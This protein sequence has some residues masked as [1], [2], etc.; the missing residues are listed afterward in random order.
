M[1]K[2]LLFLLLALVIWYVVTAPQ[3]AAATATN[4]GSV[5]REWAQAFTAFLSSL[6]A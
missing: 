4:I 3:E 5:L 6:A 2:I 1:K